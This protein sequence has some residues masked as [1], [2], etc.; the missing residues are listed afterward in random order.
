[1]GRRAASSSALGARLAVTGTWRLPQLRPEE[2]QL[3]KISELVGL[4]VIDIKDG[5]DLG[6]VGEVV[7]SPDDLKLLGFVVKS[8]GFLAQEERIV[9]ASDVR[10]IGED[11]ITVDGQEAAHTSEASTEAF[12]NAREGNRR[13]AGK[14]VITDKGSVVGTVSDAI[15][16]EDGRQLAALL[17]GGGLLQ[18]AD[19]LHVDRITSV[20]PD[21]IVVREA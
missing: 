16:D 4:K 12:R 10:A 5:T 6:Q 8:G 2:T 9:E 17:I 11:A 15:L 14:R 18:S 3:R 7:L 21:V 20:G 13:L 19:S 1:M